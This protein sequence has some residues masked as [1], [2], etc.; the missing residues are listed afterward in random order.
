MLSAGIETV[1]SE[2]FF[3][4]EVQIALICCNVEDDFEHLCGSSAPMKFFVLFY[5]AI[6]NFCACVKPFLSTLWCVLLSTSS[7]S[8]TA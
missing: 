5:L 7:I 1:P 6:C 2:V 8:Y 4:E 3:L